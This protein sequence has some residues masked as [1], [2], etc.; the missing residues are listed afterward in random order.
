MQSLRAR[1]MSESISK[2]I[3]SS[4]RGSLKVC[5]REQHLPQTRCHLLRG[6]GDISARGQGAHGKGLAFVWVAPLVI[7]LRIDL[8]E[9]LDRSI[10]GK[11]RHLSNTSQTKIRP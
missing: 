8:P 4:L 1:S 9:N 5:R 6:R 11:M 3:Q 2:L 7:K 10:F